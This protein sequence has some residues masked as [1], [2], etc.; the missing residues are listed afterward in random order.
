M[1]VIEFASKSTLHQL[2]VAYLLAAYRYDESAT[3]LKL[4]LDASDDKFRESARLLDLALR[5]RKE[6][7]CS[8]G[9]MQP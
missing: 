6:G 3:R 2:E 4:C 7:N 9:G 8:P 1:L 5:E